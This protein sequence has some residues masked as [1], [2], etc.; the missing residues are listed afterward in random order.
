MKTKSGISN[1]IKGAILS[2][3]LLSGANKFANAQTFND[4]SYSIPNYIQTMKEDNSKKGQIKGAVCFFNYN[5]NLY[6]LWGDG[7]VISETGESFSFKDGKFI[8]DKG[9]V[10]SNNFN[11]EL[12]K[13][14]SIVNLKETRD[15]ARVVDYFNYTNP[16]TKENNVFM[17][18]S[19]GTVGFK[20][21][22]YS[23]D[24]NGSFYDENNN[25]IFDGKDIL[26]SDS[27]SEK[28]ASKLEE[29]LSRSGSPSKL[30]FLPIDSK[31]RID[32]NNSLL[33]YKLYKNQKGKDKSKDNTDVNKTN[34]ETK[35][36]FVEN[37]YN[38]K[39]LEDRLDL[40]S[41]RIDNLENKPSP[42]PTPTSTST[43]IE[44]TIENPYDDSGIREDY[45]NKIQGLSKEIN[46]FKTDI[47]NSL[48]GVS[49]N[50]YSLIDSKY[51]ELSTKY[52][53]LSTKVSDLEKS[54]ISTKLDVDSL[55]SDKDSDKRK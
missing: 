55:Y 31:E 34:Q 48:S 49:Q 37:P 15:N 18:F 46:D 28:Y 26:M 11:K 38:P 7:K 25:K 13:A 17:V 8:S 19:D 1:F 16:K 3:T 32:M 36:V 33:N 27:F 21:G 54:L 45:N 51:D 35:T 43:I 4:P 14:M 9:I 30:V 2:T 40:L 23:M 6:Y 41:Q 20:Y 47:A 29:V 10:M 42:K 53:E 39:P 24:M 44:K 52:S 5:N 22:F 12:E 50:T